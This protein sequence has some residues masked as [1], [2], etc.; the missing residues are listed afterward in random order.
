MKGYPVFPT[1][2]W[3]E[4]NS[5]VDNKKLTEVILEKEETEPSVLYTNVG[6]WHS[7]DNCAGQ[8]EFQEVVDHVGE[9]FKIIY[10]QNN[11]R[12]GVTYTI[13]NLW[14]NVNRYRDFNKFHFHPNSDWSFSYYVK[15]PPNSGDIVFVDPKIRRL[16]RSHAEFCNNL[17]NPSQQSEFR[18][19][20]TDGKLVIFPAWLEHY[21]EPNGSQEARISISGNISLD[22]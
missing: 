19:F 17:N 7:M 11:Y 18:I 1:D 12:E 10:Q 2:I 13:T 6:G 4:E 3:E 8:L 20:P 14:A 22:M 5:L 9:T 16:M 21:V 15:V